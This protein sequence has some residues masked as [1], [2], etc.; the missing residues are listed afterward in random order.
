MSLT[1]SI[2]PSRLHHAR[3]DL[4]FNPG[5]SFLN[6]RHTG[7]LLQ[8]RRTPGGATHRAGG[9][10]V[11][12]AFCPQTTAAAMADPPPPKS[13]TQTNLQ[14]ERCYT[15][16]WWSRAQRNKS[17]RLSRRGE[18]RP[19]CSTARGGAEASKRNSGGYRVLPSTRWCSHVWLE[20]PSRAPAQDGVV[21]GCVYTP[22]QESVKSK[23][24]SAN[25]GG[26]L[27]VVVARI[28]RSPAIYARIPRRRRWRL[29]KSGEDESENWGHLPVTPVCTWRG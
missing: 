21:F 2:Q 17:H 13:I 20:F 16:P 29:R 15:E 8:P 23:A 28:S 11:A 24:G 6:R 7:S 22:R 5:P 14:F 26:V 9:S 27:R 12:A 3:I 19:R 25:P 18:H 10:Q 4:I 1:I